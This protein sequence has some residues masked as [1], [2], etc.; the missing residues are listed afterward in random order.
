MMITLMGI[1][2]FYKV[3]LQQLFPDQNGI[4]KCEVLWKNRRTW[5]KT[6]RAMIDLL[7]ISILSR[8]PVFPL[9]CTKN[10]ES[11]QVR[12]GSP[13]FVD[14]RSFMLKSDWL[15]IENEHSAHAQK[16][17]LVRVRVLGADQKKSGL[18]GRDCCNVYFVSS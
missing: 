9:V 14:F 1:C 3:A 16:S 11:R 6:L 8:E 7:V 12:C 4:W 10:A 18:W 15:K 13:R 5:R 2:H 17:E